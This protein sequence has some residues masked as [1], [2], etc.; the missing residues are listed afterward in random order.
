MIGTQACTDPNLPDVPQIPANL[1]GL[2]DALCDREV[3]FF[4]HENC[5]TIEQP[6]R[7]DALEAVTRMGQRADDTFVVYYGGH[8][9]RDD[10]RGDALLLSLADSDETPW[11]FLRIDDLEGAIRESPARFRILVLDCCYSGVAT[12]GRLGAGNDSEVLAS[13]ASMS[14]VYVLASSAANQRSLAPEGSTYTTF[15]GALI[16]LLLTGIPDA[17]EFIEMHRLYQH[18]RLALAGPN[19]KPAQQNTGDAASL[20]IVRNRAYQPAA[21]RTGGQEAGYF[22]YLDD[23]V[24][25]RL[26][27]ETRLDTVDAIARRAETDDMFLRVLRMITESPQVP[28]LLRINVA[29]RLDLLGD[30]AGAV[31]GLNQVVGP[32]GGVQA[33]EGLRVLLTINEPADEWPRPQEE[34]DPNGDDEPAEEIAVR[35]VRLDRLTDQQLWGLLMATVLR[36]TGMSLEG[37]LAAIKELI[38][39]G[40]NKPAWLI[41]NAVLKTASLDSA[42]RLEVESLLGEV[43]FR[44]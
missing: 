44:A 19:P 35:P 3:G 33:L 32:G 43:P 8:A 14:G 12:A 37:V 10:Q 23:V 2:R 39:L 6:S 15:T 11:S 18:L 41:L 13:Q 25:D 30:E 21:A 20:A 42:G 26:D 1:G 34:T 27:L 17:Y 22:S 31:N 38:S 16:K 40:E 7:R 4:L 24:G 28:S 29:W 36:A 9:I 5:T